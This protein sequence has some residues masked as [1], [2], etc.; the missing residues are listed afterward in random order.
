M[1]E[2]TPFYMEVLGSIGV[3]TRLFLFHGVLRHTAGGGWL[4][5][6]VGKLNERGG[7]SGGVKWEKAGRVG[8]VQVSG[9]A[10]WTRSGNVVAGIWPVPGCFWA[11]KIERAGR[12]FWFGVG[13]FGGGLG[14]VL[15]S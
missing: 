4:P 12:G 14:A 10:M 6:Q 13:F 1:R 3:D 2:A 8:V 15:H 7:N 5:L 9:I 11:G